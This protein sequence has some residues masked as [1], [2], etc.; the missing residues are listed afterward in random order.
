MKNDILFIILLLAGLSLMGVSCSKS[1]EDDPVT[2]DPP[3]VDPNPPNTPV[4]PTYPT[5]GAPS[6]GVTNA[7]LYE[8]TM[9]VSLVLPDS[10]CRTE[11]Q[12]DQISVFVGEECRGVAER[13][14]IS[15][16][17]HVWMGMVYG[18]SSSEQLLLKYY[19]YTTKHIYQSTNT[20][21]FVIDGVIG[22]IDNPEIIGMNI[23]A[24]K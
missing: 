15:Y 14:E 1:G 20:I 22:T 13:I 5:F 16:G 24:S 10:L 2:P 3:I 23:V 18:N 11:S 8:H 9:V 19:S 4:E 17:K 12:L 7:S 21:S 6:W